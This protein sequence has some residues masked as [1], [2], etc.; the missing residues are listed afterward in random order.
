MRAWRFPNQSHAAPPMPRSS[1]DAGPGT[2]LR[3]VQRVLAAG[4]VAGRVQNSS[5]IQMLRV[6]GPQGP[7]DVNFGWSAEGLLTT[8]LGGPQRA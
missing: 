5:L 4:L 7:E 6:G 8:I 2:R 3:S 1:S